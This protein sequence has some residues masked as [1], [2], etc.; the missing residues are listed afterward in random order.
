MAYKKYTIATLIEELKGFAPSAEVM[1][2]NDEEGNIFHA[3][4]LVALT[5]LGDEQDKGNP[6]RTKVVIYPL[7]TPEDVDPINL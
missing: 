5:L 6:E 1:F 7:N 2:S 3:S 4:A